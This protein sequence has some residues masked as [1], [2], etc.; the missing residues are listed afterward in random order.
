[1]CFV[2]LPWATIS[3]LRNEGKLH[4]SFSYSMVHTTPTHVRMRV[5]E[6]HER[7]PAF[8]ANETPSTTRCVENDKSKR[9]VNLYTSFSAYRLPCFLPL[10]S[11]KANSHRG[12]SDFMAFRVSS[13]KPAMRF[14]NAARQQRSLPS[15]H[16]HKT[17]GK[18]KNHKPKADKGVLYLRQGEGGIFTLP[19]KCES[20]EG[21]IFNTTKI[22]TTGCITCVGVYIPIDENRCF[23]AH[24]DGRLELPDRM[25]EMKMF[26]VPNNFEVS[27]RNAVRWCLDRTFEGMQGDVE[28]IRTRQDLKDRAIVICPW[29]TV[30]GQK[31]T[32]HH[33]IKA[34]CEYFLLDETKVVNKQLCH[35]FVV[36]H[37]DHSTQSV[38]FL[39]W[40]RPG[41]SESDFDNMVEIA[42]KITK[43]TF[44]E[45]WRKV[46]RVT[47]E[48]VMPDTLGWMLGIQQ[49]GSDGVPWQITG[50][51][52]G[53]WTRG[54]P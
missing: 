50:Y 8:G 23:A 31:A 1:M 17:S 33:F 48:Y 22:G 4:V 5:A 35:G 21:Q 30:G 20:E 32:G 2:L 45:N 53:K 15:V 52:G 16:H 13:K 41:P 54:V 38:Q 28:T 25:T 40:N 49:D 9:P 24:L 14:Q 10:R 34:L 27:C 36:D 7:R 26:Q 18:V 42:S 3:K 39:G 51:E 12:S 47:W 44:H 19:V 37:T 29:Q 46:F 43:S 6:Y 11:P